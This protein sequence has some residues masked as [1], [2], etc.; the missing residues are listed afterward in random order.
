M[1]AGKDTRASGNGGRGEDSEGGG[2]WPLQKA[3]VC[4]LV[5]VGVKGSPSHGGPRAIP[6]ETCPGPPGA[7]RRA[8][9][10]VPETKTQRGDL[11]QRFTT[12]ALCERLPNPPSQAASVDVLL[13][14]SGLRH[15]VCK[16]NK[17][18]E[19]N[20]RRREEGDD[21]EGVWRGLRGSLPAVVRTSPREPCVNAGPCHPSRPSAGQSWRLVHLHP[22]PTAGSTQRLS[23]SPEPREPP[24]SPS[25]ELAQT[26]PGPQL[27]GEPRRRPIGNGP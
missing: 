27:P 17:N 11:E 4:S 22:E 8:S 12:R 3:G 13:R 2:E 18:T 23:P 15:V 20:A 5:P 14:A 26:H 7:G 25:S 1:G 9:S 10:G 6:T 21:K 19:R 24:S 16:N